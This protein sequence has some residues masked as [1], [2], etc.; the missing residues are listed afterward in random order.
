MGRLHLDSANSAVANYRQYLEGRQASHLSA[1][2]MTLGRTPNVVSTMAHALNAAVIDGL[3]AS[4]VAK[5]KKLPDVLSVTPDY[6]VHQASDVGPGFIGASSIWW[7]TPAGQDTLFANG[8]ESLLGYRGDGV[9]IGNIDTGYNSKSPSFAAVDDQGYHIQN[10]LGSGHYIGQC[11]VQ[12]INLAGGCNDKVIGVY[13]E[14]GVQEP[15]EPAQSVEDSPLDGHGSH[16]GSTAGGNSRSATIGSFTAHLSGVAPHANLVIYRGLYNRNGSTS[17]LA[18]AA[19]QAIQD[20][21]VDV[22]N[23]SISGG[24]DPWND[25]VSQAFLSATDA[26]I[27]VAAA[28]G[29]NETT[30]VTLP[31]TANHWEPWVTTV[32]AG[33]HTGGPLGYSATV[34][35]AGAPGP[36]GM[37]TAPNSTQPSG[38]IATVLAVSP[39]FGAAN[40]CAALPSGTFT[41]KMAI[42]HFVSGPCGTNALAAN[43][44][45]AGA[46]QVLLVNS[47][48]DY[49][50]SGAAQTIPVFT[51]SSGQGNA[52]EVYAAAHPG[53]AMNIGYP[54]NSRLPAQPDKLASF[55]LLGPVGT[56][57]IKPD[58]QAPGVAVLASVA[59]DGTPAGANNVDFYDGTSM[60]TPHTAGTGA[61]L[62][63]MHSDWTPMEV[64]SAL[65]M[66]ATEAGLTKPDGATL[67]DFFDRGSG[68]I[69]A[70]VASRAG[71][72]MNETGLNFS[73]ANPAN[74][75]KPGSIGPSALNLASMQK[76][77]CITV[78]TTGPTSTTTC[79]FTR[80]FRSTQDHS[81]T[82]AVSFTG[83]V[84]ATASMPT[85]TVAAHS[86]SQPLNIR[87]DATRYNADGNFH[88]GEMVLTPS[89]ASLSPLHLPMAIRVPRPA[90]ATVP[91]PLALSIANG[92]TTTSAALSVNN[93]GGPT[94]NVTK[95]ND[96]TTT[97]ASGVVIDQPS[98]GNFGFFADKWGDK[99][100]HGAYAADDFV[101]SIPGT[102][103]SR[104]IFPGFVLSPSRGS[105]ATNFAGRK[106]HF[107]IYGDMAGV[108]SGNPD[109][110]APSYLWNYVATIGTT[111]GLNVAGNTISLD[112]TAAP[113]VTPTNLPAGK[114]WM[115]VYLEASTFGTGAVAN[116]W[117]W[118]EST[119]ANGTNA[120]NIDPGLI[121]TGSTGNWTDDTLSG[122]FP[123]MAM[124]IEQIAPCG[125]AWLTTTPPTLTLGGLLNG[126]VTVNVDSTKFPPGKT[127]AATLLCLDSNDATHPVFAVPVTATQ[128]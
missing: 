58:V 121:F 50:S 14:L 100:P 84:A 127:T 3:S 106:I 28:A 119:A 92:Q 54:A 93:I 96:N 91:S 97:A 82:W 2:A 10:P 123:G 21:I 46:V 44:K 73:N 110:V 4:D 103:V 126:A 109:T 22:L 90:I 52:L 48:D 124:H 71:L 95:T 40:D 78:S 34:S 18:A 102:N 77:A 72:V 20:G 115:V 62:M 76:D 57:A 8:F 23:Y 65:M 9:V 53:T 98:Q 55:S 12:G 89:D 69:Q 114:Y 32:A 99:G 27:F 43:A 36:I 86:N 81:V 75:G 45:A 15:K 37:N 56:D 104:L 59:N 24:L 111:A 118:F 83:D 33:N 74:A 85:L 120:Q 66:T 19:N 125:A 107:E 112:L 5:L 63:G 60:A 1:I 80:K 87:V 116:G 105:L 51:T 88:F 17:A 11:G 30:P 128:H 25:P 7:G 101:V 47:T 61:L 26:G 70:Y 35:G 79:S 42:L 38:P 39:N 6:I 68:R 31:G 113:S 64:K 108:P 16:T 49:I 29:N 122:D 67:S 41:G 94:L 117:L 13:D